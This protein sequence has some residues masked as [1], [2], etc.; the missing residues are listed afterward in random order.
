MSIVIITIAPTHHITK[1][2][3]QSRNLPE[4]PMWTGLRLSPISW[5]LLSRAVSFPSELR[6]SLPG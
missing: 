3:L 1:P 4:K 2:R 6:C 5:R